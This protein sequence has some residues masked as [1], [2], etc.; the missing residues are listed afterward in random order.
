M[1]IL[2]FYAPTKPI[3]GTDPANPKTNFFTIFADF[4]TNCEFWDF[5]GFER[6][7]TEVSMSF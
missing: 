4:Q 6:K 5:E 3:F 2:W 7:Y 1:I